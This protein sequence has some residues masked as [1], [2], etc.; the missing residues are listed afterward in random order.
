MFLLRYCCFWYFYYLTFMRLEDLVHLDPCCCFDF[1]YFKL[2]G[3]LLSYRLHSGHPPPSNWY[4]NNRFQYL[5]CISILCN[6]FPF[7]SNYYF[8]FFFQSYKTIS[9]EQFNSFYNLLSIFSCN[10][11]RFSSLFEHKTGKCQW[12]PRRIWVLYETVE[13]FI[14]YSRAPWKY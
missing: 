11:I 9:F 1:W 3:S 7:F 6:F 8:I 4:P 14:K 2:Q 12:N 10:S 5:H 13:W